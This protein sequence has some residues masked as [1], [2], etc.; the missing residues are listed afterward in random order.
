MSSSSRRGTGGSKA[1]SSA[2]DGTIPSAIPFIQMNDKG[3]FFVHEQSVQ[4]FSHIRG[5]SKQTTLSRNLTYSYAD[6]KGVLHN[7]QV[8]LM[9][10]LMCY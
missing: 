2:Q 8:K 4:L 5:K 6:L 9:S 3:Q 10:S 1:V 7:L